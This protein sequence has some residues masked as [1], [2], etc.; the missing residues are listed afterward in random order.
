M[1]ARRNAAQERNTVILGAG[2]AGLAAANRLR[3]QYRIFERL[4]KPGGLCT[5]EALK[6]FRF[7]QTGH[8]LH[9]RHPNMR[10]LIH[11][12][13]DE[14]PLKLHRKS[15]IFS[16]G[17]TTHYPFQANTFGLPKVI[18]AECL[19][20]FIDAALKKADTNTTQPPATFE[21]F[22]YRHFGHGIAKHFM[23][24]YNHKLWGVHPKEITA[25]WCNRYVPIPSIKAVVDGAIGCHQD[26]LGYNARFY[27]PATGIGS[28]PRALVRKIRTIETSRSPSAIDVRQ[29]RLCVGG[30]WVPYQALINTIPLDDFIGLCVDPP[31]DITAAA[32]KL[33]CSGLRYLDVALSR[34]VGNDY[35]WTYVPE[36]KYPFYR[37][38]CYSNFSSQMAPPKK[39]NL[40][41]ELASRRPPS[42]SRLMPRVTQG[43]IDMGLIRRESDV[44]FVVPRYLP[45]AYVIYDSNYE[46]CVPK[47]LNW[48]KEWDILCAGR[49]AR[50]EYASMEDALMQGLAAADTVKELYS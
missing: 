2:L 21:A 25:A 35:H 6:G 46:T 38:G 3:T 18:V 50:W 24:P 44:A 4:K 9:L 49:F 1:A 19:T 43:L 16:Q 37:V 8:L 31:A 39:S 17:V 26:D 33:R 13:L 20:G 29:H 7:D 48:L 5:T 41:V 11:T 30:E 45:K 32:Q 40:Y 14:P 12:L 27:Y 36:R 28:L 42:L 47:V 23:I 10:R 34:P 22:I 15:R